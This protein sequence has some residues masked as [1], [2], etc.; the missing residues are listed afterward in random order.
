M[1]V[2]QPTVGYS[3][4]PLAQKLGIKA[5]MRVVTL[6]APSDYP[7][8]LAPM[9]DE[10]QLTCI[11]TDDAAFIHAFATDR[12]ALEAQL[13]AARDALRADGILWLSWPKKASGVATDLDGNVVRALGLAAGLVDTKVCAID[14][15]W[16]GLKF[17]Y[18]KKDRR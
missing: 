7:T 10:V 16:S 11:L 12:A 1:T 6:D 4:T 14:A 5:G 8:L 13:P 15:T 9:P 17:M 18:R 2:T 3:G